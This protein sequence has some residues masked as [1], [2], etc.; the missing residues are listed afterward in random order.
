MLDGSERDCVFPAAVRD[1]RALHG[2]E[3]V[4]VADIEPKGFCFLGRAG[5]FVVA[6]LVAATGD[7]CAV[8]VKN[9]GTRN[10][11]RPQCAAFAA[12]IT[13]TASGNSAAGGSVP[14]GRIGTSSQG[15]P[16]GRGGET[17][18]GREAG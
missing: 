1:E 11:L 5:C 12:Q 13:G 16:A 15:S 6:L 17:I 4:L 3:R 9:L 7:A 10:R 18:A 2:C 8:R 14:T